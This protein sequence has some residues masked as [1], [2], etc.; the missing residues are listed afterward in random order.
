[1]HLG[2]GSRNEWGIDQPPGRTVGWVELVKLFIDDPIASQVS[3]RIVGGK[4]AR[5]TARPEVP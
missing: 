2:G 5:S 4:M 3:Q 1:M